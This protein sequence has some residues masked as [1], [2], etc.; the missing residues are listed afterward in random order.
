[1]KIAEIKSKKNKKVCR[2]K[3]N[4]KIIKIIKTVTTQLQNN[5]SY[6]EKINIDSLKRNHKPFMRSNKSIS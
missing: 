6:L 4:L 1:M 3:K 5:I 2:K